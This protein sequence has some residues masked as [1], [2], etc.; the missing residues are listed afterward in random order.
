MKPMKSFATTALVVA[1]AAPAFAQTTKEAV[2][3]ELTEQGYTEIKV[4]KT[5]F[6]NYKIEAEGPLGE[7]ELVLGKDGTVL[8]DRSEKNDDD[9]LGDEEDADRK[10]RDGDKGD[11]GKGDGDKGEGDK[12]EGGKGEGDNGEGDKGDGDNGEG[13]E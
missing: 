1:L 8:R 2:I 4:R 10:D 13:D 12:G 7:R 6:G 3:Q 5:L 11:G 9:D